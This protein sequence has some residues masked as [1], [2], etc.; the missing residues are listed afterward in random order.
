[1][2][3]LANALEQQRELL[4]PELMPDLRHDRTARARVDSHAGDLHGSE[5][6][7]QRGK[8]TGQ[9]AELPLHRSHLTGSVSVRVSLVDLVGNQLDAICESVDLS[10]CDRVRPLLVDDDPWTRF[11]LNALDAIH[12]F[13]L[14]RRAGDL[15]SGGCLNGDLRAKRRNQDRREKQQG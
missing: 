9:R 2:R 1:M 12:A 14:R 11:G 13:A 5:L 8:T 10:L 4:A 15:R 3:I 7:L 6:A